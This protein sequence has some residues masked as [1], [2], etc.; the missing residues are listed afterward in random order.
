MEV[1][2]GQTAATDHSHPTPARAGTL[3]L[4]MLDA[5]HLLPYDPKLTRRHHVD[6]LRVASAVCRASVAG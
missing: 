4:F 5:V 3:G 6:L 2:M 1:S